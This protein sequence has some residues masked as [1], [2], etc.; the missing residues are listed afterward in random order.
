MS[1]MNSRTSIIILIIVSVSATDRILLFTREGARDYTVRSC[2]DT[3]GVAVDR[4]GHGHGFVISL[5]LPTCE[6]NITSPAKK[7]G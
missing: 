5:T 4:G 2:V 1:P 3:V 6:N 7:G